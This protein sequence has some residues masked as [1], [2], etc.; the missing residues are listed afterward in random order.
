MKGK[1]NPKITELLSTST[2][3]Q[4]ASSITPTPKESSTDLARDNTITPFI[5]STQCL[6]AEL[7]W[8]LKC[9]E[10]YY[11]YNSCKDISNL[12]REMFPDSKI[13]EKF[14]CGPT[15]CSYLISFGIAPYIKGV[16]FKCLGELNVYSLMFDEALNKSLQ[17]KQMDLHI[18]FWNEKNQEVETRYVASTF[19]GHS[20]AEDI[21]REFYNSTEKLDLRKVLSLS[22]DGPS[23]NWKFFNLLND[24]MQKEFAT[25]LINVGSCSLHVVNNSFRHGET[26][27]K[28]DID[29]FLSSIYYLFKDSPARKEDYLKVSESGKL[30]K[31]FCRTRWLEN[32]AAAERAIEMWDDLVLYVD[33]IEK[34][35]IPTPKCKSYK[36]IAKC[37]KDPTLPVKLRFFLTLTKIIEPFLAF[38]QRD[39]PLLP[40]LADDIKK[41]VTD[42]LKTFS[43]MKNEILEGLTTVNSISKFDFSSKASYADISKVSTGFSGDRMLKSLTFQKKISKKQ[44]RDLKHECQDFVYTFIRRVLDKSPLN[45]VL[46]RNMSCLDPRRMANQAH[47]CFSKMKVILSV[48]VNCKRLQE[49]ECD[50]ILMEFNSFLNE[51]ACNSEEFEKFEASKI[52]LDKF[53][54][55]YLEGKKTYQKLWGIIKILLILSHGQAVV[56]RGFSVNKNIEVENLKEESYV[57][58]RLILDELKKCGG[59][60]SFKI[61]KELRL[62]AKNARSKYVENIDEQKLQSQND[63]KNKKRKQITDELNDLKS[64]RMKIEE[65]ASALQKSADKL[66]EK[67]EKNRDFQSIAESNSFRKTAKEKSNEVKN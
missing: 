30:P 55:K 24:K 32:A 2:S 36:F 37:S 42:C 53:L 28:W 12:F 58:K 8:S 66:A 61:T 45:Y 52:R 5:E 50:S 27:S 4:G 11:S 47:S 7:K 54:S 26:V 64:K 29:V 62:Y 56:E 35:K 48:L 18:R 57:A 10:S 38:Y 67:A 46:A 44:L 39:C 41:M 60:D 51:V 63:E 6:D 19:M 23:V 65:T 17:A 13:A 9:I 34:G 33:N 3:K 20:T 49:K 25:S 16:L 1:G 22:M 15:K 31:K 21:L 14:S 59:V 43:V 40:F